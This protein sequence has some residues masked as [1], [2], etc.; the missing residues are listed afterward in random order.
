MKRKAI[1]VKQKEEDI[2]MI[3]NPYQKA[4]TDINI[5]DKNKIEQMIKL[6]NL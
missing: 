3:E 2:D 5:K 4:I 1:K 6:V